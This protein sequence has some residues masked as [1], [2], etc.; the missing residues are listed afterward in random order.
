MWERNRVR[1]FWEVIMPNHSN[2]KLWLR[3]FRKTK[4]TFKKVSSEIGMLVYPIVLSC[5]VLRQSHMT[6]HSGIY[7]VKVFYNI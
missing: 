5:E 2:D 7:S 1:Q 3:P 6:L 4:T